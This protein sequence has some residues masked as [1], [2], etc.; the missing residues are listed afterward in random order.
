MALAL[1]TLPAAN[2]E[3]TVIEPLQGWGRLDLRGVWRCREL[4]LFLLWR[5][6]KGTYRQMALGGLWI[7]LRPLLSM[8]VFNVIFGGVMKT[9]TGNLP[10]PLFF[11]SALVPWTF[12]S[13]A[14]YQ[15]ATSLTANMNLISKVYFPRLVVPLAGALAGLVD[16]VLSFIILLLMS[17]AWGF[18]PGPGALL[19]PLFVLLAA[20]TALGVGLWI[21]ALSVKYRDVAF[22]LNYLLQAWM[23]ASPVVYASRL[24]PQ[25]WQLLYRMNP[26][27]QVIDA[28]RWGLYGE[29]PPP[30][31]PLAVSAAVSILILVTGA[32]YFQKAER[33]VV[34]LL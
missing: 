7:I 17:L 34:D 4:L 21:G 25:K 30:D 24:V 6:I 31:W 28:F 1:R 19:L 16:L 14:V 20:A 11:Y 22:V 29:A 10:G 33:T 27:T 32:W 13:G 3:K 18:R 26:M 5:D 9:P 2:A 12:F 15:S 23:Y 8:V